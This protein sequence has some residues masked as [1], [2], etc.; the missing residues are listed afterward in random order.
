MPIYGTYDEQF[1]KRLKPYID[2]LNAAR[3]VIECPQAFGLA[4]KL[5]EE[6]ADFARL[7]QS[8]TF[9]NLSFRANVIAYLK[10]MVLYVANG[11]KWERSFEDFIR[12]SLQYDLYCK[13]AFFGE[14]IEKATNDDGARIGTRGPRNLLEL[15]PNEF[16]LDDARRV[17]QQQG[18]SNEGYKPICMI[19]TWVNRGYV[20]QNT[21][22]SFKKVKS[23]WRS[24]AAQPSEE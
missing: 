11:C 24:Q 10:A 22:Y 18:L 8:R 2:N 21:E 9:E 4:K 13:M 16:T 12:W 14:D 19:R 1:D 20:I 15:L 5:K 23:S 3:G 17:R 6:N 7:S